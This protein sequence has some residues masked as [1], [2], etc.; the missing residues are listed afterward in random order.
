LLGRDQFVAAG[1]EADGHK[2]EIEQDDRED[3]TRDA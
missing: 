1:G 2:Q 3:Q